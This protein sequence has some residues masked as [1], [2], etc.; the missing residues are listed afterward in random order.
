MQ[1]SGAA[2]IDPEEPRLR[3]PLDAHLKQE[4]LAPGRGVDQGQRLLHGRANAVARGKHRVAVEPCIVGVVVLA[5]PEDGVAELT[6]GDVVSQAL[7]MARLR[8]GV[9]DDGDARV[10]AESV[11]HHQRGHVHEHGCGHCHGACTPPRD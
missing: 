2:H 5:P 9:A 1:D 11:H 7:K 8:R 6:C 4:D 10:A 3:V